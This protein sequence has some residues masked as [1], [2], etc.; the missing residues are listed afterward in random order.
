MPAEGAGGATTGAR[1]PAGD[2][3]LAR[4]LTTL[5]NILM[6]QYQ[7]HCLSPSLIASLDHYFICGSFIST[8]LMKPTGHFKQQALYL[9]DNE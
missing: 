3:M 7:P 4:V 5:L 9:H 2:P 6:S 8:F 1:S